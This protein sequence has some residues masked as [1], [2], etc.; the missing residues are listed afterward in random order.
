MTLYEFVKNATEEDARALELL[1][2]SRGYIL[3]AS[4]EEIFEYYAQH[5][6]EC[7]RLDHERFERDYKRGVLS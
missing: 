4:A 1:A 6:K 2:K 7:E 3:L 5:P